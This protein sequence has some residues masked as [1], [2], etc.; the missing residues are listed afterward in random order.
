MSRG[1]DQ[2]NYWNE[3]IVALETERSK[4][5]APA[6][7]GNLVDQWTQ[8]RSAEHA[9]YIDRL[10][11][12]FG[13][14]RNDPDL[15]F[16][17]YYNEVSLFIGRIPSAIDKTLHKGKIC[18]EALLKPSERHR[19]VLRSPP[20]QPGAP[21]IVPHTFLRSSDPCF[22]QLTS[23]EETTEELMRLGKMI[24]GP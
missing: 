10:A 13:A 4:D 24:P 17:S 22:K 2:T 23:K 12:G 9:V 16:A 15:G 8:P 6:S 20:P 21:L 1:F 3:I 11:N 19:L 7:V 5:S 14:P 18:Q